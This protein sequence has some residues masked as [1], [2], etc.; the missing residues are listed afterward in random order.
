MRFL[1]AKN[2]AKY[3]LAKDNEQYRLSEKVLKEK[4]QD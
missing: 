2:G 1:L 3:R 4:V